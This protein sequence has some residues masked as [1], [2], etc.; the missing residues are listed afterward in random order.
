[1]A[2]KDEFQTYDT[3]SY[4]ALGAGLLSAGVSAY[5]FMSKPSA[6]SLS[7]EYASLGIEMARLEGD[8]Q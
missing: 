3:I 5:S 1:M 2:Y 7:I 6:E 8:L 4:I